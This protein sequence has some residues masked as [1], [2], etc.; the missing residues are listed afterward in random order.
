M[1]DI[2][3]TS[4]TSVKDNNNLGL[5]VHH[6]KSFDDICNENNVTTLYI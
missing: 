3:L 2:E 1:L 6:A 5:E 4:H